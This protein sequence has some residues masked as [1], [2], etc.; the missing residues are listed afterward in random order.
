M[1]QRTIRKERAMLIEIQGKAFNPKQVFSVIK[2]SKY[3]CIGNSTLST[4][5]VKTE[6]E[7]FEFVYSNDRESRDKDFNKI[8]DAAN[9]KT[10]DC[11]WK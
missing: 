9:D 8:M 10:P 7:E 3:N 1:F 5:K 11:P 4:L 6:Y 2:D